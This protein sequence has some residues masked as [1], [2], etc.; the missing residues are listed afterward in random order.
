[1]GANEAGPLRPAGPLPRIET[2]G[3][4]RASPPEGRLKR[5]LSPRRLRPDTARR[6]R[7]PKFE[8]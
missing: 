3:H 1:M 6:S 4:E 5:W 8:A 7:W 2:V